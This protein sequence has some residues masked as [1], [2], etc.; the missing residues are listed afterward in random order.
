MDNADG[1]DSIGTESIPIPGSPMPAPSSLTN[2]P[3]KHF[4]TCLV[5][6]LSI[7]RVGDTK[8][9]ERDLYYS[10][11]RDYALELVESGHDPSNLLLC[12]LK[13]MSHDEVRDMLDAN[14]LSPRFDTD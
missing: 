4:A 12:C 5:S 1:A 6:V 3:T 14:E 11:P 13:F 7:P 8:M 9:P 10:D 2:C